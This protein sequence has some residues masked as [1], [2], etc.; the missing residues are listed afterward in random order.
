[1]GDGQSPLEVRCSGAADS[2]R[3]LDH[4]LSLMYWTDMPQSLA[5]L[6]A[7]LWTQAKGCLLSMAGLR[8][9]LLHILPFHELDDLGQHLRGGPLSSLLSLL[10]TPDKPHPDLDGLG[11]L[12]S[13][14]LEF[15]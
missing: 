3:C 2:E 11:D 14:R 5:S 1:M 6:V 13:L 15:I 7:S 10:H 12:F 8:W 4:V 9:L